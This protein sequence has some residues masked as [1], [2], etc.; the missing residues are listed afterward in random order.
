M[1]LLNRGLVS[2]RSLLQRYVCRRFCTDSKSKKSDPLHPSERRDIPSDAQLSKHHLSERRELSVRTFLSI[3]KLWTTQL[4]FVRTF[5]QHVRAPLSVQLAMDFFPK[6][7][8]GK[9]AATVRTM[10][11]LIC[12][13]SS[14]RK[15]VHSKSRSLDASPNG[16]DARATYTKIKCIRSTVRMTCSMAWMREAFIWK[17]RVVKVRPFRRQ[18]KIVPSVRLMSTIRTA[19]RFFKLDAYL[20]LQPINRG[21]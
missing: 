2:F 3:E 4:A 11:I 18:G 10:W 7:K 9:T 20:K 8:Y 17:L 16:L 1:M 13:R 5:Q 14:I 12:T 6:H 19:P 15:V 21:P